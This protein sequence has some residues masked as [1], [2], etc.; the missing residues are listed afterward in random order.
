MNHNDQS[1]LEEQESTVH[2]APSAP[3]SKPAN[4]A[5]GKSSVAIYLTILFAAA[6]CLL[7][8]AYLIQQRNNQVLEQSS[9]QQQESL[10]DLTLGN[11]ALHAQLNDLE[12]QLENLKNSLDQTK[13]N[14][15]QAQGELNALSENYAAQLAALDSL[16]LAETMLREN[17]PADCAAYLIELSQS[18]KTFPVHQAEKTAG[19]VTTQFNLSKRFREIA[20]QLLD[21]GHLEQADFDRFVALLP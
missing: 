17:R 6:F 4:P 14:L 16:N 9:Q 12:D 8:M 11:Q 5:K 18:G 15:T 7:L 2:D 13:E 21:G 19:E 20:Q 3:P 1:Q 10:N